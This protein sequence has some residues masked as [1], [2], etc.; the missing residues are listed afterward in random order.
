MIF[1]LVLL[2]L[3]GISVLFNLGHFMRGFVPVSVSR[4]HAVGPR[5]EEVT[6]E[7]NDASAKIAVVEV[8]GIITEPR[9]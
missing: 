5:L 6:T 1:A 7:D 9:H 3:L 8:D 4:V 2:V